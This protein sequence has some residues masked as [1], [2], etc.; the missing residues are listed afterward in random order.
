MGCASWYLETNQFTITSPHNEHRHVTDE[1]F[2]VLKLE[3]TL[4][5]K[6]ETSQG[7]LRQIFDDEA[8]S[9]RVGGQVSFVNLES[10]IYKRRKFNRPNVPQD[11]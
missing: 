5:R 10:S 4:K 2:E 8:N 1:K 9:S 3:T 11:A 6:S 7:T